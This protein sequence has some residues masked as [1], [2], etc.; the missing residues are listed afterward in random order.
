MTN[1][2]KRERREKILQAMSPAER[3]HRVHKVPLISEL[4][5][6]DGFTYFDIET[7]LNLATVW[8]G[9]KQYVGSDQIMKERK[10]ICI[11]YLREGD[12]KVTCLSMDL[13]KHNGHDIR[14]FDD[15]AD[16]EMLKQFMKVVET[17]KILVAH[18]GR[19]FD[20]ARLNARLVHF[21]L[22]PMPPVLFDDSYTFAK[23]IGFTFHKLDY[24]GKCLNQGRKIK[25]DYSYWVQLMIGDL[26]TKKKYLNKMVTYCAQ[27]VKLLQTVYKKLRPYCKSHM[28]LAI[29]RTNPLACP[30]CGS[31]IVKDGFRTVG[32]SRVQQ[33][34]CTNPKCGR[35][36][37][38]GFRIQISRTNYPR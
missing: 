26:K 7:S 19:R 2:H 18:N 22:P 3:T 37:T 25:T 34:A 30:S 6:S 16:K 33:V 11:C 32:L 21:G 17:S 28:N 38:T 15:D 27:D 31:K 14:V 20:I 24:L 23:H 35:K 1:R 10:I 12:K 9:G 36:S 4:R 13:K 29:E 8:G 5:P